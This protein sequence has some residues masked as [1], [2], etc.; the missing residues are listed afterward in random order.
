MPNSKPNR[1][2]R[3]IKKAHSNIARHTSTGSNSAYPNDDV[4]CSKGSLKVKQTL[5]YRGNIC[6][7][8]SY[9]SQARNR[10]IYFLLLAMLSTCFYA[11]TFKEVE[12]KGV[13]DVQ[14]LNYSETGAE[15]QITAIIKN[16]NSFSFKIKD[17]DMDVSMGG[18]NLGKASLKKSF[19]IKANS[20]EPYTFI[21]KTKMSG[22]LLGLGAGLLGGVLGG[23]QAGTIKMKGTVKGSKLGISKSFPMEFSHRIK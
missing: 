19:R 10:S 9:F 1:H 22:G 15:V 16:P 14:M 20:E 23:K 3:V 18:S 17:V 21:V 5:G 11:C 4:S 13:K 8:R 6:G 12:M 2:M 7:E